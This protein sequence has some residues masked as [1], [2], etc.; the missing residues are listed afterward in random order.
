VHLR[1]ATAAALEAER[2]SE[3][4]IGG[5]TREQPAQR[6]ST[7]HSSDGGRDVLERHG[8]ANKHRRE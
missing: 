3:G 4:G 5:T 1:R 8:T 2:E 7:Q 6:G